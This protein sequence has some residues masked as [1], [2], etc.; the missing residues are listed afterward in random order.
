MN[1]IQAILLGSFI[2]MSAISI[3]GIITFFVGKALTDWYHR[4]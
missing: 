2:I 3:L 4:G 1:D